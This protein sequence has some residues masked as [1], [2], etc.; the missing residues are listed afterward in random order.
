MVDTKSRSIASKLIREFAAGHL[1]NDEF[2]DQYPRSDDRAVQTMGSYLWF[3]WDDRFTHR[4]EGEH[5][6][7]E[8]QSALLRR[9]SDFLETDLEYRGPAVGASLVDRAK[10]GW[11]RITGQEPPIADDPAVDAPWWPFPSEE[12]YRRR[13]GS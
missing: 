12:E 13:A 11:R 1:T 4:L 8:E 5:A 10:S 3:F 2:D 9:M 6:L 7:T